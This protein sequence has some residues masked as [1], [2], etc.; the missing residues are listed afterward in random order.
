VPQLAEQAPLLRP[1]SILVADDTGDS[2]QLLVRFLQKC[3]TAHIVEARN[4][5]DAVE[6]FNRFRPPLVFLDI[7]MP[8]MDGMAALNKIRAIEQKSFCVMVT[9]L[10]S[11]KNVNQA[12]A[13]GANAFV[14]KPYSS[15][16]IA[17][18]M[19]KFEKHSGSRVLVQF[20]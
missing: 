3:T 19:H 7:D 17:E 10:S 14:V 13:E 18:V 16:R 20:D 6:A 11:A 9:G 2:R 12:L 1:F 8:E 15:G 4:G 5:A